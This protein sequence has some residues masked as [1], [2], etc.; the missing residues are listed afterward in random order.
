MNYRAWIVNNETGEGR[1]HEENVDEKYLEG[2]EFYWSEGNASCDCNRKLFW[3]RAGGIEFDDD[4]TPCGDDAFAVP[5][6]E[7][8]DGRREY[9]DDPAPDRQE[10][11]DD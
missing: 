7:W 10:R 11:D 8:E 4:D 2:T 1:W 9:I 6:I 3:G 5:F